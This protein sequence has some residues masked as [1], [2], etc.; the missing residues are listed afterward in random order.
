MKLPRI[1]SIHTTIK[2]LTHGNAKKS[3]S[4]AHWRMVD[5][6]LSAIEVMKKVILSWLLSLSKETEPSPPN[7]KSKG[8]LFSTSDGSPSTANIWLK[9]LPLLMSLEKINTPLKIE[10][11]PSKNKRKTSCSEIQDTWDPWPPSP[12]SKPMSE[13]ARKEKSSTDWTTGK[14]KNSTSSLTLPGCQD[15]S[16]FRMK[17]KPQLSI[18]KELPKPRKNQKSFP[19][20]QPNNT[21]LRILKRESSSTTRQRTETSLLE[22]L[23]HWEVLCCLHWFDL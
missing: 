11:R 1:S 13:E 20:Q 10:L 15:S 23:D 22:L 18:W 6:W 21:S 5:S 17:P 16:E 2:I 3:P 7:V 9:P 8:S 12:L 4:T 19:F 14:I